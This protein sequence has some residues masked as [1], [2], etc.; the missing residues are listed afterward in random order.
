V[1]DVDSVIMLYFVSDICVLLC[2]LDVTFS[3][4]TIVPSLM[5]GSAPCVH[6]K[7]SFV[8]SN[9]CLNALVLL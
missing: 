7:P 1:G 5:C 6:R 3:T 4:D 8:T 9:L 2:L